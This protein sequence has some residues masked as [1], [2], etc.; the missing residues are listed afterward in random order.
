MQTRIGS[1]AQ[2][3]RIQVGSAVSWQTKGEH[4]DC[5]PEAE[6]SQPEGFA[7]S[8]LCFSVFSFLSDEALISQSTPLPESSP[9]LPA[10]SA[11]LSLHLCSFLPAGLGPQC[12]PCSTWQLAP[13]TLFPST[14]GL[15]YSLLLARI[16][17]RYFLMPHA[18]QPSTLT[19]AT[20]FI[21]TSTCRRLHSSREVSIE[22]LV[23]PCF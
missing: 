16:A 5:G 2:T 13:A 11:V 17:A 23:Q 22:S 18:S 1:G 20:L 10:L 15:L 12:P 3:S 7:A 6:C 14:V 4:E 9:Q 8:L 19:E 21:L